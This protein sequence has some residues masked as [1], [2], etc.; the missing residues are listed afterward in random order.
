MRVIKLA[1]FIYYTY[2]ILHIYTQHIQYKA[3][4]VYCIKTANFMYFA[5]IHINSFHVGNKKSSYLIIL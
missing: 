1:I 5:Y 3:Y 2:S 4:A